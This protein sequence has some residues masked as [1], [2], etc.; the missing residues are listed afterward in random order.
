M[1]IEVDSKRNNPLLNRTEVYF[2]IHHEGEG[3]PNRE[4]IRGELAEKL[5][6]KKDNIVVNNIHS[7]FGVQE[8]KGYA[9]V[10]TSVEKSKDW[11]RDHILVRNKIIEKKEK[12]KE[13]KKPVEK[14]E[15]KPE[16]VGKPEKAE[17]KPVERPEI[18]E[19]PPEKEEDKP[20]IE[21]PVQKKGEKPA[22]ETPKEEAGEPEKAEKSEKPADKKKQ[23]TESSKEEPS[24]ES[25]QLA[26]EKK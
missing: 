22:E 16:E 5:N 11:D 9:K 13:E 26:E 3:T 10:Y 21:E 7:S 2:I 6:V 8:S 14:P 18:A 19:E 25:G 23:P 17:E 12:K 15:G 4:I 20:P 1:K 24:G